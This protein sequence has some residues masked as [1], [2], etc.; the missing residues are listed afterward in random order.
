MSKS[1]VIFLIVAG[2]LV[3]AGIAVFLVVMSINGW[4]FRNLSTVKLETNTYE[5]EEEFNNIIITTKEADITILPSTDGKCKVVC[6]E[7]EKVKHKVKVDSDTLVVDVKDS[8]KWYDYVNILSFSTPKITVYIPEDKTVSLYINGS[9][10]DV[11]IPSE[12]NFENVGIS[13][14][15]GD[16]KCYASAS[17]NIRIELNTGKIELAGLSA[18]SISLTTSTGKADL[19]MIGC[20]GDVSIATGT[21]KV[22]INALDCKNLYSTGNTGDIKLIGVIA[23]EKFNIERNTG[24]VEFY[25]CDANEI[26]VKTSTGNIEGNL[27]SDK[28]FFTQTSTGDVNVTKSTTGGKCE[29]T[30]ST[31]NIEISIETKA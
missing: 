5:I 10:G 24:D 30:S 31:G 3:I 22:K 14:S 16:V 28:I 2:V 23:T 25:N 1:M 8:R 19:K 17:G 7:E 12:L 29:L 27:L 21:G 15:T 13:A 11:E 6:Y 26:F 4:N 9:T 20:S 18:E